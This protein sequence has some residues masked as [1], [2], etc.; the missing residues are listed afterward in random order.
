[1]TMCTTLLLLLLLYLLP[2]RISQYIQRDLSRPRR[3]PTVK[4]KKKNR[5]RTANGHEKQKNTLFVQ[6]KEDNRETLLN[7]RPNFSRI[8]N[9]FVRAFFVQQKLSDTP[10][11]IFYTEVTRIVYIIKLLVHTSTLNQEN[12]LQHCHYSTVEPFNSCSISASQQSNIF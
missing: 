10:I 6:Q 4:I 3:R 1:M 5:K 2:S 8:Q 12:P 7:A 11:L 9:I